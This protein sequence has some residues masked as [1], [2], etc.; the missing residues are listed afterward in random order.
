MFC[1]TAF[2]TLWGQ[3]N[4]MPHAFIGLSATLHTSSVL[5]C[6]SHLPVARLDL[7]C[8]PS[9]S[10]SS[11][12]SHKISASSTATSVSVSCNH[13]VC[14]CVGVRGAAP[15]LASKNPTPTKYF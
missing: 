4:P 14:L 15:L 8:G 12:N 7:V 13:C 2:K 3:L 11:D 1:P 9:S 5:L 6:L 10:R